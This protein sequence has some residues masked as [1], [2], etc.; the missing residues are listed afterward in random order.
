MSFQKS[1]LKKGI[2]L[3]FKILA[4]VGIIVLLISSYFIVYNYYVYYYGDWDGDGIKNAEEYKYGTNPYSKDTDGDGISDYDEIFKYHTD[5]IK[6]DSDDDGINDYDE[7]FV[8]NLDP[9]KPNPNV[10]YALSLGLKDYI[11]IIKPLDEEPFLTNNNRQLIELM[12]GSK[13]ILNISTFLN[14]LKDKVSDARISDDELRYLKNLA[15]LVK[16]LYD[17]VISEADLNKN[18]PNLQ[19]SD[20]IKTIDYSSNLGLK[21][22]FDK[23]F[24]RD[25]T[26]KAIGYYGIAVNDRKLPE[27]YEAIN[28]LTKGTQ[29]EKY[30]DNLVDFEPIVFKNVY[31]WNVG[32][33]PDYE[34]KVGDVIIGS[35]DKARD[36]WMIAEL[37]KRRPELVDQPKKFEWINRMMQEVSFC[38]FDD[39]FGPKKYGEYYK[40]TDEVIW[41]DVILP[42]HD[43]MDNLPKNLQRDG[44][45]ITLH[46]WDSDLLDQEIK[47]KTNRTIALYYLS[48][49]PSYFVKPGDYYLY[50]DGVIG[51][52]ITGL[53]GMKAFINYLPEE[54]N[55]IVS[56]YPWGKVKYFVGVPPVSP[57]EV[58]YVWLDDRYHHNLRNTVSE[59]VG[60][61]DESEYHSRVP[62]SYMWMENHALIDSYLTKEWNS[63]RL[64]KFIIGYNWASEEYVEADTYSHGYPLGFR[65][66]G[67]PHGALKQTYDPGIY[68]NWAPNLSTA[69]IGE[70]AVC[71]PD[72]IAEKLKDKNKDI[73]LGY[74]NYFGLYSFKDGLLK[75]SYYFKYLAQRIRDKVIILWMKG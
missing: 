44:L 54:Y 38:I 45:P 16:G 30:G 53:E 35:Y 66:F 10:S 26:I 70:W 55:K 13:N 69:P 5:P 47:D 25:A 57:F 29:I 64:I 28:L 32:E 8:Y 17:V 42:F 52:E 15:S 7:I 65:A 43:Y 39:L 22:G 36:T 1:L 27:N 41:K 71:L 18:D 72:H 75:D 51:R 4:V 23:N 6:A 2:S 34:I 21:L 61:W 12:A 74:G 60:G 46:Y 68:R 24:A 37:L 3:I 73:V 20:P 33:D 19:I 56:L 11:D 31:Y 58:Y 9:K 59:F 40:P 14:Y 50:E 67:I 62:E 49:L 48:E 63:W